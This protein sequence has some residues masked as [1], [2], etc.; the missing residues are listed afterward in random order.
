MSTKPKK[1]STS[2]KSTKSKDAIPKK[3]KAVKKATVT[4]KAKTPVKK[5]VKSKKVDPSKV[6]L[7]YVS[8]HA[9]NLINLPEKKLKSFLKGNLDS[10]AKVKKFSTSLYL[11]QFAAL[12]TCSDSIDIVKSLS[13]PTK[14]KSFL[15]DAEKIKAKYGLPELPV[16]Y[17]TKDTDIL[18]HMQNFQGNQK[19]I[20]DIMSSK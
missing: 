20:K 16:V 5:A 6:Y 3:S 4:K 14:I 10:D 13:S 9:Q 12:S 2:K 15:V 17:Y 1:V 11:S 8:Y 7:K 18:T 19:F